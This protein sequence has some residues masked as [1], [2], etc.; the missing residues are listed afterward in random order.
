VK[1]EFVASVSHELRT[2]L[3]AV[4]GHLELLADR[5][6]LPADMAQQVRVIERNAVRLRHLVGDLLH[7][8]QVRDSGLQLARSAIDLGL[9]VQQAVE[10]AIPSAQAGRVTLFAD[11]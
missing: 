7:V 11:R 6:D 8:A 5:T 3:T 4:L 9:L 2:P 1:D 10:A